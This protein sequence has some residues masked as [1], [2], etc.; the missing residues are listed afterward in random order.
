MLYGGEP[1]SDVGD[2]DEVSRDTQLARNAAQDD[3][4]YL[5]TVFS[6]YAGRA[7]IWR[8]LGVTG[9]YADGFSLSHPEASRMAGRRQ[10]G[11]WLN[12]E[13]LTISQALYNLMRDEAIARE[14]R[15]T[16]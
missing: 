10:I 4:D 8:M 13:V 15:R 12:E 2:E 11:L 3:Q 6:T 5:T 1:M 14:R 7:V 16:E 9:L